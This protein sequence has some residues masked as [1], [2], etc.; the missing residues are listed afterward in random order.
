MKENCQAMRNSKTSVG[1]GDYLR[2]PP[3]HHQARALL[4]S[5]SVKRDAPS[6]WNYGLFSH[7]KSEPLFTCLSYGYEIKAV[8]DLAAF[9]SGGV[10]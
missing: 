7:P 1:E 9:E 5:S 6:L 4:S 3:L 8:L 10:V 2:L